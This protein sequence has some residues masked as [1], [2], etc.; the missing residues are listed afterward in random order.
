MLMMTLTEDPANLTVRAVE[1]EKDGLTVAKLAALKPNVEVTVVLD[2]IRPPPPPALKLRPRR[3]VLIRLEKEV[4]ES[5][6]K[7]A[8]PPVEELIQFLERRHRSQQQMTD[9]RNS[10]SSEEVIAGEVLNS[11]RLDQ[12]IGE[13]LL[14]KKTFW[15][16]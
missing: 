15:W 1:G 2:V 6:A 10:S 14:G 8:C 9:G 5:Q 4:E 16:W 13:C 3:A 7:N 12:T 11:R